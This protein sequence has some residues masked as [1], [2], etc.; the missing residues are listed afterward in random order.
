MSTFI[1]SDEED[2]LSFWIEDEK[3]PNLTCPRRTGSQLLQV[4]KFRSFNAIHQRPTKIRSIH[5]KKVD[6]SCH[7]LSRLVVIVE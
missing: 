7:E 5:F 2:S 3:D 4:V 1:S 6:R